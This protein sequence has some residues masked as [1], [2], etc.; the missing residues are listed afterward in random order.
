M[1]QSIEL[2]TDNLDIYHFGNPQE[3]TRVSDVKPAIDFTPKLPSTQDEREE[4]LTNLI[5]Q[6]DYPAR[7]TGQA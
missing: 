5:D 1:Q 7:C 2:I 6:E 3:P 4:R